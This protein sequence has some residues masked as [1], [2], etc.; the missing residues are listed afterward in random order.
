LIRCGTIVFST[1]SK[2]DCVGNKR[3][4]PRGVRRKAPAKTPPKCPKKDIL[5]K[6]NYQTIG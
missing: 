5:G 3:F 6:I 4:P 1:Y 2:N